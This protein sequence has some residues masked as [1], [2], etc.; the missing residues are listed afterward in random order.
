MNRLPKLL[1]RW[2]SLNLTTD[3]YER[4]GRK[5]KLEFNYNS[6]NI[7][8]NALTYCQTEVLLESGEV[9]GNAKERDLEEM[10]AHDRCIMMVIQEALDEGH[11]LTEK[12]IL[13]LH[14]KMFSEDYTVQQDLAGG[15]SASYTIHIGRYKTRTNSIITPQGERFIYAS[16]ADTP[17]MMSELVSWYNDAEASGEFNALELATLFHYRFLR[18]HPFEEGSG[19]IARLLVNYILLRHHYPMIVVK[20]CEKARYI[21]ALHKVDI[22]AN[23]MPSASANI[24][25]GQLQPIISYFADLLVKEIGENIRFIEDSD[26]DIWW[27]DGKFV[28]F[29]SPNTARMLNIISENPNISVRA[30]TKMLGINKSAVQ[31]QLKNL[32]N[33]NYIIRAPGKHGELYVTAI[34]TSGNALFPHTPET[35]EE[36]CQ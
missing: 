36:H 29:K 8:G 9:I 32:Q 5:F 2:H 6:N 28:R 30:L 31:K 16:P 13:E 1:D 22:T 12:F 3:D 35:E 21:E 4:L 24:T 11:R 23:L 27:T 7:E 33:N 10:K 19:R 26:E 17:V 14:R 18:I 20:S 34:C 25:A 15:R